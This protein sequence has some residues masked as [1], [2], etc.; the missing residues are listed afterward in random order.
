MG[1]TVLSK[2]YVVGIGPG[3]YEDMTLRA[4]QA[5]EQC[6]LIVGYKVYNELVRPHFPDKEYYETPMTG[7]VE[8]CRY[9]LE[10]AQKGTLTALICSGDA[11]VYGLAGL[12]F[13]LRGQQPA[14]EI[15]VI[16]GLT[17][18]TTGAALL[19]SPLTNDFAVISL[20][21]LLTPWDTIER[22]LEA[23]AQGD[24]CVVLYNPG[25]K[26]R[27]DHLKRACQILLR[28][29]N[30]DTICGLARNISR[31]GQHHQITTLTEL[32]YMEVDMFTTVFIGN[33]HTRLLNGRMVTERGYRDV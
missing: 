2:L 24:L 6:A 27:R 18:A 1:G 12:A 23:A 3:A 32:Q 17:A 16:P 31:E 19:G 25:S 20:S 22:R 13:E 30:P 8:R 7:E 10:R 26:K 5:L 28:H 33:A 29:K 9:A 4:I 14:P 21:D 11:G 15:E